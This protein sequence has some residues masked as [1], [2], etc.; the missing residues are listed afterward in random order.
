M[1]KAGPDFY[2]PDIV[3]GRRSGKCAGT[4]SSQKCD[5]DQEMQRMETGE[6]E[7]VLEKQ[8]RCCGMADGE[9]VRI[10]EDLIH[11]ENCGA[12]DREDEEISAGACPSILDVVDAH[13]DEQ[14][15]CQQSDGVDRGEV[16][17]QW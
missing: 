3:C 1:P 14:G 13:D 9:V 10:L 6:H 7:V 4:H 17:V 2:E 15:S 12:A 16:D 11:S 8:I 5:T